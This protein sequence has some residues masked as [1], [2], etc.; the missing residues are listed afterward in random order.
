MI[1]KIIRLFKKI[2]SLPKIITAISAL[3]NVLELQAAGKDKEA[4]T[5]LDK[6]TGILKG[7]SI[8][9]HLNRGR[10]LFNGYHDYKNAIEEFSQGI[11]LIDSK[12]KIKPNRR[13]YLLAW[14]K[15][16][17][18]RCYNSGSPKANRTQIITFYI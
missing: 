17:I 3:N 11:T 18:A 14:T 9:Y 2:K 12:R 13:E 5:L 1:L 10:I 6:Y 4:L 15:Y 16:M 7:K 8:S